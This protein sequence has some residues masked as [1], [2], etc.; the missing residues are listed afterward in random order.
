MPLPFEFE[1]MLFMPKKFDPEVKDR[2]VRMPK[3]FDP[4]VKDRAVRMVLDRV[5]EAG[6]VTKAVALVSPKVDVGRETLRRWVSQHRVDAGLKDGPTSDDLAE[7]R[8]LRSEVKRL[9]E[10]NELLRKASIFFAGDCSAISLPNFPSTPDPGARQPR[11]QAT[12]RVGSSPRTGND[13][14]V[15][16]LPSSTHCFGSLPGPAHS[17]LL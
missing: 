16:S 4:E 8:R 14:H 11:V 12:V 3:K 2:A 9:R 17:A 7:L 6:S 1:R 13:E 15:P 5:E 10:D